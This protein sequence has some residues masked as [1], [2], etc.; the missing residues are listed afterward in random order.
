MTLMSGQVSSSSQ[1]RKLLKYSVLTELLQIVLTR[2]VNLKFKMSVMW[3]NRPQ[4][5]R[6]VLIPPRTSTRTHFSLPLR[7][8][9]AACCQ[10]GMA[11]R[12]I[13]KRLEIRMVSQPCSFTVDRG[14]VAGQEAG[15]SLTP[16]FS[17][18]FALTRG[19]AGDPSLT[20]RLTGR[21]LFMR[22]IL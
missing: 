22:I 18:L 16:T 2:V 21:S 11:T 9:K 7:Q 17:E 8:I 19:D 20:L 6:L 4:I 14:V 3:Q 15:G 10:L 5:H 12:Y 13:G 1:H